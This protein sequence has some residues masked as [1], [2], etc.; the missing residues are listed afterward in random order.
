MGIILLDNA[1]V[2]EERNENMVENNSKGYYI[3]TFGC[4]MNERDT[5]VLA[6]MLK[7][8]GYVKS[9]DM[10]KADIILFNTCCV[11]EKAENKVLSQLGELKGL[12]SKNPQLIIGVCGCMVQQPKMAELIRR[13]APHVD[14]LFGTHNI[15]ELPDLIENHYASKNPQVSVWD[16]EGKIKEHL[17]SLREY[18]FK[19]LVNITYGCNNFCTYCIVPYVRGR[20]RSRH[21]KHIIEEIRSLVQDGVVEVML[22][23][24]NVNSYGKDLKDFQVDFADLLEQIE[25]IEGLKRVRYMTSHPRDFS[26]KLIKIISQSKKV[27]KHFHLPVQA[28]SNKILEKMNRGYTR[29]QYLELIG[30]IRQYNPNP[31]ITTDII[32]GFPGETEEDFQETLSLV[33]KVRFDG[34]FTFIYSART[35][36]P[37]AKFKDQI[38]QEEKRAR[39]QTLNDKINGI[40]KEINQGYLNKVVD[41]LVE[42]PSKTNKEMLTGK[43]EGNK[44]VIFTGDHGNIGKIVPVLITE[45][46]TWILKGIMQEK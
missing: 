35:G 34:A 7:K 23:G 31:V 8:L 12:K 6:G 37:A 19:A 26:E 45:P 29:E 30:K 38:P 3:Q 28:G 11:R 2:I 20:E 13:S 44:T 40:G 21:P 32:V 9:S 39:I 22:L 27:C 16:S 14:L 36:T 1:N 10:E 33:E 5:E 24:Q 17:P 4:Q 42:G 15:H 18:P 41:V 25:E 43:T 46:Q